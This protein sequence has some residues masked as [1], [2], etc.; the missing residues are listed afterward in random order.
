M[1]LFL[2]VETCG[3]ACLCCCSPTTV[4][5]FI[6]PSPLAPRMLLL[7]NPVYDTVCFLANRREAGG[8]FTLPVRE[9]GGTT[10]IDLFIF[11]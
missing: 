4:F 3:S 9:K 1:C 5:S 10:V 2:C 8:R 11:G 6:S 7:H